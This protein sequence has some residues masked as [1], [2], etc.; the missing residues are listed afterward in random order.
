[1]QYGGVRDATK[2]RRRM[3]DFRGSVLKTFPPY[4]ESKK[5]PKCY[6]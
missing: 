5:E 6:K 2:S 4:Y 1:M 3:A